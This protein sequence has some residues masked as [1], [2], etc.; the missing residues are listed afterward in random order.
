[1]SSRIFFGFAFLVVLAFAL[2]DLLVAP[3]N[4]RGSGSVAP[5]TLRE[6]PAS[7]RAV[8]VP[9]LIQ[10]GGGSSGSGSSSGG[11]YSFGK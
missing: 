4:G 11:G 3:Y 7:W 8:Y 9:T 1:M 5:V 2:K 10:T 6:N